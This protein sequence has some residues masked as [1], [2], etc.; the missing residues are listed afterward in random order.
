[1]EETVAMV[2]PETTEEQQIIV[3]KQLPIIQEQLYKVKSQVEAVVAD[4]L[5]LEVTEDTVTEIKNKRAEL[6]KMFAA[7]EERRKEV[8][9][10]VLAP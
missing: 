7:F 4:A 5:A 6:N 8:K 3:I 9:K 10:A 2:V 1:M